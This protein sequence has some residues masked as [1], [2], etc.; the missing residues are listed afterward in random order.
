MRNP[1]HYRYVRCAVPLGA[2]MALILSFA[3]LGAREPKTVITGDQMEILQNGKKVV[4]S[5]NSRVRRGESTLNADQLVQ[6]KANNRI[7]AAGR[8]GFRGYTRDRELV[9]GR[10]EKAIYNP[11]SGQGELW[12]GRPQIVY[13]VKNSTG[14]VEVEADRIRFDQ[15]REEIAA[16]G[17]VDIVS[18]SAT[19][20]A[21]AALF[22]QQEK[23]VILTGQKPQP[24]LVYRGEDQKG[25]Y[26]ADRITMLIDSHTV[27]LEG[28][29][30]GIVDVKEL[31]GKK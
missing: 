25:T 29:V 4:F 26:R 12:E 27:V 22:R 2:L 10:S 8:I 1:A 13:H 5:G 30:S 15:A 24:L 6:D 3:G 19:A 16:N 31:D 14:P 7:E 21:P 23:R 9:V 17:N 18:S 11:D 20:H 28:N